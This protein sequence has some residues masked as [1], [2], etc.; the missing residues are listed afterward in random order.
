VHDPQDAPNQNYTV[1]IGV[2]VAPDGRLAGNA[3]LLDDLTDLHYT[4]NIRI[5]PLMESQGTSR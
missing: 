3:R 4:R 1:T 5:V 2:P